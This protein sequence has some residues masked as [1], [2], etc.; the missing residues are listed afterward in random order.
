[1]E[2]KDTKTNFSRVFQVKRPHF[3]SNL[4]PYTLRKCLISDINIQELLEQTKC[5]LNASISLHKSGRLQ[6][7]T[8]VMITP[9]T[10]LCRKMSPGS[11]WLTPGTVGWFWL[12]FAHQIAQK[13]IRTNVDPRWR[14][15]HHPLELH[16]FIVTV[17]VLVR[18]IFNLRFFVTRRNFDNKKCDPAWSRARSTLSASFLQRGAISRC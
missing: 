12:A 4:Q 8:G 16:R 9:A 5:L 13:V 11:N 14:W 1:M 10:L 2:T 17:T 7:E 18:F 3:I 6:S 15:C